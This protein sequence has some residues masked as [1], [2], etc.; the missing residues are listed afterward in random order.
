[1][2]LLSIEREA[3][4]RRLRK[5][6]MFPVEELIKIASVWN[7]SLDEMAGIGSHQIPF[8]TRLLH[9]LEPSEEDLRHTKRVV[10]NLNKFKNVPD[11]EYMEISN[12]LPRALS[13]GFPYIGRYQ[14]LRWMYQFANKD[15]ILPYSRIFFQPKMGKLSSEYYMAMKNVPTTTFIW[16]YMLFEFLVHNIL[17]FH[18][19]YLITDEEKTLIKNEMYALLDYLSDVANNG[20][21]PESGNTVNLYISY[22]NVETNY[23]Y[24]YSSKYKACRVHAFG[25]SE[26]FTADQVLIEDFRS[27]MQLMTRSSFQISK[28]DERSR[29]EFFI[30]QRKLVDTL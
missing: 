13:A 27:W 21:W 29:I 1:M 15:K 24:Y 12:K 20:C 25:K 19:I 8:K 28:A 18:S 14:L 7:I 17:Y 6:V 4:Y 26:I 10:A 11:M 5:D 30:K 9:Y 22:I 3:A 23:S 16:D 2:D